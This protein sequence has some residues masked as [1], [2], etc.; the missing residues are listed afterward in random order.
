MGERC[1]VYYVPPADGRLWQRGCDWLGRDPETGR[2][3]RPPRWLPPARWRSIV[4]GAAYYGLHGTLKAPFRLARGADPD[5]L[6]RHVADLA[7]DHAPFYLPPLDLAMSHEQI[8]LGPVQ[9]APRLTRLALDCVHRLE[10]LRVPEPG[11][12]GRYWGPWRCLAPDQRKLLRDLG[13]PHT[14]ERFWFHITLTG[15]LTRRQRCRVWPLLRRRFAP[16][17]RRD[18]IPANEV[19]VFRRREHPE[20]YVLYRRIPLGSSM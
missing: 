20:R 18:D 14:G 5:D 3:T 16:V 12:D 7:H 8:V 13:Y 1:A 10:H 17:L 11:D 19:A 6:C 4:A 9:P 2:R 15:V